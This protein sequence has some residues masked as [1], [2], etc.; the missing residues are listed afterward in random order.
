MFRQQRSTRKPP[1]RPQYLLLQ[2][3]DVSP[4]P[5]STSKAISVDGGFDSSSTLKA[6][7]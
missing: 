6:S 5:V 7:P 3:V 2:A 1:N 4:S